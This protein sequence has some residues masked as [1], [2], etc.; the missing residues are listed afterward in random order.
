MTGD[1]VATKLHLKRCPF[2][3]ARAEMM[4]WHGGPPTKVLVTCE[5][6]DCALH[7]GVCG[8]TPRIAARLWN[9]RIDDAE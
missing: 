7:P 9:R 4:E 1:H 8:N 3:G 5:S 2:C 6:D